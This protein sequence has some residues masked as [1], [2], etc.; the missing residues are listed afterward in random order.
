MKPNQ[1]EI[2]YIGGENIKSLQE[3]PLLRGVVSH[4]FEVLLLVDPI[5]EY[6]IQH[7]G[8]YNDKNLVNIAKSGFELPLEEEE[9]MALQKMSKYY[10]PLTNWLQNLLSDQI[11]SVKISANLTKDPM[12][13]LATEHGYSANFQKI[14]KAQAVAAK[15]ERLSYLENMKKNLEIN[16]T[17]PF[18][19]LLLDKIND[20]QAKDM[21]D[22]VKLLY[23]MALL[24]SGFNVKE[25]SQFADKFYRIMSDSL[26][27]PRDVDKVDI[28][29]S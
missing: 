19:K 3:S 14:A 27:V 6:C 25:Q 11:E 23:E 29:L 10:K 7:V 28:D 15:D 5:D 22:Q 17:H 12:V 8:K 1:K 26:G 21:E 24:N 16:P 9:K 18:I 2:Y 4:G 13:V 20:G